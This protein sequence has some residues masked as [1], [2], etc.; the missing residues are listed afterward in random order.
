MQ[1]FDVPP[2]DTSYEKYRMVLVKADS[3]GIQPMQFVMSG[4]NE[5]VDLNRSYFEMEFQMK[6][7]NGNNVAAADNLF[8][9]QN[10]CHTMIK[11]CSVT[12]NGTLISSQTD[13]YPYKAY[14]ETLINN[15]RLDGETLLP[16]QGFQQ[17]GLDVATPLTAN[18][19]DDATP[20]ANYRALSATQKAAV[21]A[22]KREQGHYT[23]GK[24]R[25]LYFKPHSEAFYMGKPLVPFVEV[26][27]RFFFHEPAFFL[28]GVAEQ[29]RL[30]DADIKIKFHVCQVQLSD[31]LANTLQLQRNEGYYAKYPLVR[32]EIRTYAL[33]AGQTDFDEDRIFLHRV[34]DRMIVGL[35]HQSS[36]NGDYTYSPFAFQQF[37]LQWI[38]QFVDGE[39]YPYGT[40]L[41]LNAGDGNKDLVGYFRFVQATSAWKERRPNLVRPQEW[42]YGKNCTLYVF[43]NVA[44]GDA[45]GKILNPQKEGNVRVQFH[46]NAGLGHVV[47]VV[48]Y[49]EFENVM[50]ITHDGGVLYNA[51]GT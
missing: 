2:T 10:L 21:K 41:E 15:D 30:T 35:L 49:G 38:K 6:Q 40:T 26:V 43:D 16:L 25:T 39:E 48:I 33:P 51:Y 4:V 7:H 42:G 13:T 28:N 32:S 22:M 5:Y 31:P 18:N 12:F 3:G 24:R 36:Y 8:P 45:D 46:L 50:Q 37:G 9:A 17:D 23:D 19:L 14:F 27:V 20:H 44:S 11:Q 1:I 29:G 47:T 34:P